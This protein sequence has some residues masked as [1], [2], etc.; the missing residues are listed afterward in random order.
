MTQNFRFDDVLYALE[1]KAPALRRWLQFGLI[2][3]TAKGKAREGKLLEFTLDD[4][5]A[6]ALVKVMAEFGVPVASAHKIALR[7]MDQTGPWS[8]DL[9]P[10]S[11]WNRWP[12]DTQIL[13][14][15]T[16]ARN[17][18]P[19]WKIARFEHAEEA[20]TLGAHLTLYPHALI[21]AASERAVEA[22]EHR[23]ATR[24]A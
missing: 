3:N 24:R 11:F 18:K 1:M 8:G 12:A 4:L 13:I 16:E 19:A 9:E 23:A 15:R 6:L 17:G 10:E 14:S 7:E 20:F 5:A 21:K 22:V 2:G